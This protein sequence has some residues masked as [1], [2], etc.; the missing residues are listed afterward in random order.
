M[1]KEFGPLDILIYEAVKA[2][3]KALVNRPCTL[4]AMNFDTDD[5]KLSVGLSEIV[6]EVA[7]SIKKDNGEKYFR[8]K[9]SFL[10]KRIDAEWI[11]CQDSLLLHSCPESEGFSFGISNDGVILSSEAEKLDLLRKTLA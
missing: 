11:L 9:I 2:V 4:T 1:K 7:V 5:T 10:L 8:P 3:A 6:V